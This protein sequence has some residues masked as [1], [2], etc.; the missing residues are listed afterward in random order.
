MPRQDEAE[1]ATG[2]TDPQHELGRIL[3]VLDGEKWFIRHVY[4]IEHKLDFNR[5]LYHCDGNLGGP[6]ACIEDAVKAAT[7]ILHDD[8]RTV[9]NKLSA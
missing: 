4:F 3:I 8:Q 2:Q 5:K 7:E 1:A 9:P 6:F